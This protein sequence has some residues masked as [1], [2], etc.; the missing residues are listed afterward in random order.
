MPCCLFLMLGVFLTSAFYLTQGVSFTFFFK[1]S[2]SPLIPSF[3]AVIQLFQ[4]RALLLIISASGLSHPCMWYTT[5]SVASS[6]K[7]TVQF[8]SVVNAEVIFLSPHPKLS[9]CTMIIYGDTSGL[10]DSVYSLKYSAAN[11]FCS[12]LPQPKPDF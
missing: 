11:C 4:E 5:S 7:D 9:P 8:C 6:S 2:Y 3:R 10:S 1:G 12:V